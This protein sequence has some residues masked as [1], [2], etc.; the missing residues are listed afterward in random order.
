MPHALRPAKHVNPT[1]GSC[2]S[3]TTYSRK[4]ATL[5][6][7]ELWVVCLEVPVSAVSESTSS[8][9]P[10]ITPGNVSCSVLL[11]IRG[12]HYVTRVNLP[13]NKLDTLRILANINELSWYIAYP[14]S[15]FVA[16]ICSPIHLVQNRWQ[17]FQLEKKLSFPCQ[18]TSFALLLLWKCLAMNF[19]IQWSGN[20]RQ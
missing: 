15:G 1:M 3:T 13:A 6:I 10:Q 11:W 16:L 2:G 19:Y 7:R 4:D 17:T 5:K 8:T 20:K 12:A 14:A 18:K 9:T